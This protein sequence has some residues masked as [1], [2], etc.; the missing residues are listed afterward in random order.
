MTN[1]TLRHAS[2]QG[3][4]ESVGKINSNVYAWIKLN[5]FQAIKK[6]IYNENNRANIVKT[7]HNPLV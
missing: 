1:M 4:I 5:E 6:Y 2:F 3:Q 7:Q